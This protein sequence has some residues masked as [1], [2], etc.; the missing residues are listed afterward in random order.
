VSI[1]LIRQLA[2]MFKKILV[3]CSPIR[4][5][6]AYMDFESIEH[7][8]S[9]V[10]DPPSLDTFSKV[11]ELVWGQCFMDFDVHETLPKHG[12]GATAERISGNQKYVHRVWHERL[13]PFFPYDHHACFNIDH[14]VDE[15][16]KPDSVSFSTLD[17]EMPVRVMAVPKTLKGPRII[18]IEPVCMQYTQQALSRYIIPKIERFNITSG[19]INFRDQN[20]NKSLAMES[21]KDRSLASLDLSSASDRVPLKLVLHMLKS[22]PILEPI[23]ACRSRHANLNGKI[24]PLNKFASMG[25]ALCFP[26]EAMYFF[27]V[28]LTS[29]LVK[30]KMSVTRRN[31]KKMSR[32]VYI[33]GDDIF[34][35]VNEVE[36][37][38][39]TLTEYYCKVNSTKSFWK[40]NFRES[41]GMDS[42]DGHDVTPTYVRRMFPNDRAS[43]NEIISLT[44]TGNLFYKKGYWHVAN[45]IKDEIEQCIGKLPIVKETSPSLGWLTFQNRLSVDRYNKRLHRPEVFGYVIVPIYKKDLIE[46][47]PAMVKWHLNRSNQSVKIDYTR[48]PRSGTV[49]IKRR[50]TTSY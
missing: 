33:Y 19:H 32:R 34:I 16:E 4:M 24:L 36:S 27:T 8:L 7:A 48:T 3:P 49:R 46:G 22:T 42:Y 1:K 6:K 45:F 37:V 11:S 31:I 18:A 43:T 26:V 29:L 15:L 23:L 30:H 13:Q 35:P 9:E 28:I 47:Y 25:S 14:A 5:N 12:P 21:S 2:Y 20:V 38:I 17:T 50:W 10:V 44:E 41:C 40:G 39:T